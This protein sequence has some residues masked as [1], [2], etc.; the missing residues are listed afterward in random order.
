MKSARV[1][2]AVFCSRMGTKASPREVGS[3]GT[4]REDEED[5][6]ECGIIGGGDGGGAGRQRGEVCGG[7]VC[8]VAAQVDLCRS[9][10][11]SQYGVVF[12]CVRIQET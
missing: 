10:D 12:D 5:E 7:R 8:L 11:M 4:D 9:E 3:W 1:V 2:P 6:R